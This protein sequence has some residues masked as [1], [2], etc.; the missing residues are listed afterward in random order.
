MKQPTQNERVAAIAIRDGRVTRNQCFDLRPRITRLSARIQD[1]EELG[2]VFEPKEEANDFVY[3]LISSPCQPSK[4]TAPSSEVSRGEATAV[5]SFQ[6]PTTPRSTEPVSSI[7]STT[8]NEPQ[9]LFPV[10][11]QPEKSS[12][13]GERYF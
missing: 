9:S 5:Q 11:S 6:I 10:T 1:L 7:G 2:W 8:L 13:G 3:K 4:S 12:R